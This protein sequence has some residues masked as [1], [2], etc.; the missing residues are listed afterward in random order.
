MIE[1]EKLS[2]R[3][4]VIKELPL[5]AT[6][7]QTN[8]LDI[9]TAPGNEN[10]KNRNDF[11]GRTANPALQIVPLYTHLKIEETLSGKSIG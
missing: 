9:W 5:Q 6:N 11:Y 8:L 10:N 3:K 4:K 7:Q 2:K 1:N